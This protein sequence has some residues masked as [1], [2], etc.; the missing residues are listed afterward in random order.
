MQRIDESAVGLPYSGIPHTLSVTD[1]ATVGCL[2]QLH[3]LT[4]WCEVRVGVSHGGTDSSATSDSD[5]V[6]AAQSPCAHTLSHLPMAW[7]DADVCPA[8][9]M[10]AGA[11]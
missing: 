8:T 3:S 11:A 10:Q 4:L 1:R 9:A 5:Y 7:A 6:S 2:R